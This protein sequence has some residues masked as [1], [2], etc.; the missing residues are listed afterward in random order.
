MEQW[1]NDKS[2]RILQNTVLD[3]IETVYNENAPEYIYFI[4]LYNIFNEFLE[5]FGRCSSQ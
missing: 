5:H 4:T 3:Y 2:S 1:N